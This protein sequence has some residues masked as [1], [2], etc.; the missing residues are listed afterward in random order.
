M[1]SSNQKAQNSITKASI[2]AHGNY[3]SVNSATQ[4]VPSQNNTAN[5]MSST[6]SNGSVSTTLKKVMP[7]KVYKAVRHTGNESHQS[8]GQHQ[9]NQKILNRVRT[10]TADKVAT[11]L[12]NI[13]AAK[14]LTKNLSAANKQVGQTMSSLNQQNTAA[15]SKTS[16]N[17]P[18]FMQNM[19]N[20]QQRN[21]HK[22]FESIEMKPTSQSRK[23]S[24]SNFVV[25]TLQ[26]ANQRASS[27]SSHGSAA[28]F[29]H[30]LTSNSA[31]QKAGV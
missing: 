12:S 5:K 9:I 17:M 8:V 6:K 1:P 2:S 16:S 10:S 24:N 21:L 28:S 15:T 3:Q 31:T 4:G 7:P 14:N 29:I 22:Q 11:N 25:N 13:S 23:G 30:K 20:I 18:A 26:T 19:Q 27:K